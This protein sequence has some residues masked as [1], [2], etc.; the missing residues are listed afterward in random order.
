VTW[1]GVGQHVALVGVAVAVA[2]L[3]SGDPSGGVQTLFSFQDPA[4]TESSGLVRVGDRVLTH[5]D[6]G[7]GPYVYVVDPSSGKTVGR[8]TYSGDPVTDV[9][10][11]AAGPDGSIWMGDIG[12]NSAS[13]NHVSV[14]RLPPVRDGNHTVDAQR[15][16]LRYPDGP[17]NAETLLVDPRDGR[18]YVVSKSLFGGRIYEAPRSLS[19][20]HVNVLRPVGRAAGLVTDG[21]FFPD[22]RHVVLRTYGSA[23]V[24]D[25]ATWASHA[26]MRL[27]DQ[28]QGEG[29][30]V[31]D[32]GRRVLVSSEG[33]HTPVL[34]VALTKA[35]LASDGGTGPPAAEDRL[36]ALRSHG[37]DPMVLVGVGAVVLV[38]GL[39]L[40]AQVRRRRQRRSTT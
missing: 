37:R 12:D 28:P 25:T 27:P 33:V 13:R 8:T 30:T 29:I 32:G 10:A 23:T 36:T 21:S 1:W 38:G 2:A 20:G 22:G 16:D 3:V 4:I 31:V 26:G 14:Y 11:M 39:A 34:S 19:A 15:Y 5:N 35:M 6:S 24:Y 17:T 7:D 18:L 9:E 40:S